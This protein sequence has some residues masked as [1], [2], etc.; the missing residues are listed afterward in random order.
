MEATENANIYKLQVPVGISG[1]VF[2]STVDGEEVRSF[3]V[4][5]IVDGATYVA[6]DLD[7]A[8]KWAVCQSDKIPQKPENPTDEQKKAKQVN[9]HVGAD[10]DT[11][12]LS[13]TTAAEV[14]SKVVLKSVSGEETTFTGEHSYSYVSESFKH[15]IELSGLKPSTKYTYTIG[16]GNYKFEGSFTT[17]P[18]K[19]S[20][21]TLKFAFLADTQV[22]NGV[23]AKAAGATFNQ[24]NQIDDLGFIY[25]GGDITDNADNK[26]QW[27]TLF[28]NDGAYPTAGIDCLSNNLLAVT[29]GN[30]DKNYNNSSLS[31]YINAPAEAGNLVYSID[32]GKVKFIVLNLET[33][34]ESDAVRDEQKAYLEKEV[35][36]AKENGQWT[37]VG[38]HKSIYTGASHIVD[39][40]VKAARKYWSPVLAELDVDVVLEAHD[41]VYARGFINGDGTR[42]EV[43]Q[44]STGAYISKDNAPLYMVGG[45]AGGLKW[46][47]QKDYTVEEG[48]PLLPNYEFLDVNS[49]DGE[50]GSNVSKEQVYTIFEVNNTELKSTTYMF[51]YDTDTDTITTEPY[52]YD[53]VTI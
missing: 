8:G 41:H 36:D 37:I 26:L 33:A 11:V 27:E 4:N 20:N 39:S 53:S 34:K 49:T 5:D 46:Y 45:H 51:K 28:E 35:A 31:N 15:K 47:S 24:L 50:N 30:H 13:F 7:A 14:E 19:G 25:I 38:F 18:A 52:V 22:S 32:Y 9:T 42:G 23:N 48:N 21:A 44:D 2:N 1:M 40:D 29:Q 3:D 12:Y 6:V 43:E 17:V 10:Y 16:E